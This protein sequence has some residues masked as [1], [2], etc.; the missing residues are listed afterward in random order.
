MSLGTLT[1]SFIGKIVVIDFYIADNNSTIINYSFF[2]RKKDSLFLQSSQTFDSISKLPFDQFTGVPT[3]LS[4]NGQ[5]VVQ[6]QYGSGDE[7]NNPDS[8]LQVISDDFYK[9]KVISDIN[10]GVVFCRK[11]TVDS[12]FNYLLERNVQLVDVAL[13]VIC[14]IPFFKANNIDSCFVGHGLGYS[15]GVVVDF[16]VGKDETVNLLG[17]ELKSGLVLSYILSLLFFMDGKVDPELDVPQSI[18]KNRNAYLSS[19]RN[20]PVFTFFTLFALILLLVNLSL[21][22]NYQSRLAQSHQNIYRIK[23][24]LAKE[25]EQKTRSDVIKKEAGLLSSI[26]DNH[27][28]VLE[29]VGH[30]KPGGITLQSME[31]NPL[32]T[33]LTQNQEIGVK[34]KTLIIR[35]ASLNP[36]DVSEWV[37]VLNGESWVERITISSFVHSENRFHFE[38]EITIK[39]V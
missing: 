28:F 25:R 30:T 17:I 22:D 7:R 14:T 23:Q 21:R 3:I 27:P 10:T 38:L 19:V 18:Q 36:N 2:R 37:G 11:E 39:N 9:S 8:L 4:F 34:N 26:F 35:G 5:G 33:K 31:I 1:R 15:Q 6:K 24:Q 32:T 29:R 12:I 16:N 13:G 20:F